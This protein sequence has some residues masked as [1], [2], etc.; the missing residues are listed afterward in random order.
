[1]RLSKPTFAVEPPIL[2]EAGDIPS[3]NPNENV[4]PTIAASNA[5]RSFGQTDMF[6]LP[7]SFG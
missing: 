2:T 7:K 4:L 1:M 3:F 5:N 6:T